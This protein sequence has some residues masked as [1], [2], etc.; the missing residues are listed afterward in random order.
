[1][2]VAGIRLAWYRF[3]TELRFSINKQTTQ[4]I[5]RRMRWCLISPSLS[6]IHLPPTSNLIRRSRF[7]TSS[8]RVCATAEEEEPESPYPS[9][10][11]S[12]PSALGKDLKKVVNKTAATFAPRAPTA[13]KKPSSPWN[14][15]LQSF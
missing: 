9:S 8:H 1:M 3:N 2:C 11:S 14:Y 12:S 10:S 5:W 4:S 6:S 13:S 15:S 7:G